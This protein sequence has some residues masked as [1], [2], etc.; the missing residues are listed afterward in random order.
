MSSLNS[1][2]ELSPREREIAVLMAS[3]LSNRE[4]SE[5]LDIGLNTIKNHC[6]AI[7][8]KWHVNDRTQAVIVV[9]ALGWIRPFEAYQTMQPY[10][11]QVE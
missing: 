8:R 2:I 4:I 1:T 3:G 5:A 6:T 7:Y 9:F 10:M 11:R